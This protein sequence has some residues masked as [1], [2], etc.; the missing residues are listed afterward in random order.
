MWITLISIYYNLWVKPC[1]AKFLNPFLSKT[2]P[3][4]TQSEGGKKQRANMWRRG[5]GKKTIRIG[6]FKHVGK[7]EGKKQL[8]GGME[9]KKI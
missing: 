2:R 3:K 4:H 5:D 7:R 6:F 8:F 1:L 9:I